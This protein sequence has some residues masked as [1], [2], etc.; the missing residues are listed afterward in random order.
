MPFWMVLQAFGLYQY[1]SPDPN[2]GHTPTEAELKTGRAPT[3]E[4]TRC[5]TYLALAHGANG[6]IYYCYYDMR[7]LPQYA[8]MWGWMKKIGAEVKSLSP[9]LLSPEDLGEVKYTS[10]AAKIHTKLKISDGRYYLIAVNSS[11]DPAKVSFDTG[12]G[13]SSQANVL[14]E[15]RGFS[16]TGGKFSDDFKPFEAHIYDLGPAAN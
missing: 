8:T 15:G 7:V 14:F 12:R 10:A 6:L 9:V 3:Y 13:I 1:N 16:V 4:E 2:R 5:M 11:E